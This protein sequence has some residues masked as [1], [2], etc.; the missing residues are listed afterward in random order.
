VPSPR[1]L[2]LLFTADLHIGRSLHGKSLLEDQ[3]HI[4]AALLAAASDHHAS[5]LLIGGDLFD[6]SIPA[7]EAVALAD[8][9]FQECVGGLGLEVV[10]VAGNHDSPERLD[11]AAGLLARQG[12]HISGSLP[13]PPEP[14]L[15][16][17]GA[18]E[19]ELYALP[20][21]EPA[22]IHHALDREAGA[23]GGGHDLGS[24]Q[25][26]WERLVERLRRDWGDRP[27]RR[28]L[29]GHL[30]A[31]GGSESDSERP[32][33]IG[34]AQSVNP[35]LLA[36]AGRFDLALLGHLHR[37]QECWP[38]VWYAGSPLC[39]GASEI[40]QVKS[41]LLVTVQEDRPSRTVRQRPLD[42]GPD[43][44]GDPPPPAGDSLPR[45]TVERVPLAPLRPVR[46]LAGSLDEL[47]AGGSD[48]YVYLDL[49]E[50]QPVPDAFA[51]LQRRYP[52][53][54]LVERH[55]PD[56]AAAGTDDIARRR[57]AIARGDL[58]LV[59]TFIRDMTGAP[60]PANWEAVV[61]ETLDEL[62]IAAARAEPT[63][64]A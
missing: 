8:W 37:P 45:L 14:L 47:L 13:W 7:A 11:F 63:E 35:S 15:L 23:E 48:D 51:R 28:I 30:F 61:R 59:L 38:G 20:Y 60:A 52:W 34:G 27:R 17:S 56:G 18:G 5:H 49:L 12:L 41:A 26:A 43:L 39:Y 3:R 46:R 2:R 58:D 54:L 42:E 53:L 10:V 44:F 1:Q 6:R 21:A 25:A 40:G 9:F 50:S 55:A 16:G 29:L 64:D 24:H 19:V 31:A 32:L 4:L 33:S 62:L 36:G 57:E 22:A